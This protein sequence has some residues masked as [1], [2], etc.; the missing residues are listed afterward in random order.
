MVT[1]L[2]VGVFRTGNQVLLMPIIAIL[3]VKDNVTIIHLVVHGILLVLIILKLRLSSKKVNIMKKIVL[4]ELLSKDE[5][6][7]IVGGTINVRTIRCKLYGRTLTNSGY[8][9]V[10]I[11]LTS[12]ES[13]SLR[14]CVT[15]YSCANDCSSFCDS[16]KNDSPSCYKYVYQ[17][18]GLGEGVA[19][20]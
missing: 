8:Q 13:W 20:N 14:S 4:K 12:Q 9:D 16:H 6:K 11:E 5:L 10:P 3:I 17:S 19:S 2:R 15:E 18:D 1:L 7:R